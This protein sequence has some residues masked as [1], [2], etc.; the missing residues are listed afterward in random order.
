MKPIFDIIDQAPTVL[1]W[2]AA[3]YAVTVA[4]FMILEN[5]TPEKT[6]AWLLLFF[7]LPL[8]GVIIYFMFGRDHRA[9]SRQDRLLRQEL[10]RQLRSSPHIAEFLAEQ[11]KAIEQLKDEK[12]LVYDR[13]LELMRRNVQTPLFLYN[14]L[15][16]L[17]D[18]TE[19]L[20]KHKYG[21]ISHALVERVKLY[22]YFAGRKFKFIRLIFSTDAAFTSAKWLFTTKNQ[23]E[24][25]LRVPGV[26][27]KA[28]H[29]SLIHI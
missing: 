28:H 4:V 29:L 25:P 11:P 23:N 14:S 15:E 6:F 20:W 10:S 9:F 5:R 16:I 8:V 1:W 24:K 21:L 18:A 3:I 2:G 7:S 19:K 27:R 13:A 26:D 17:Q 22:P 12:P